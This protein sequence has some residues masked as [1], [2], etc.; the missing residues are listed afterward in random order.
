MT[1]TIAVIILVA[2]YSVGSTCWALSALRRA[3]VSLR[4]LKRFFARLMAFSLFPVCLLLGALAGILLLAYFVF[5]F[6]WSG[7]DLDFFMRPINFLHSI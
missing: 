2:I 5:R 3:G 4:P 7:E 1:P 6:A